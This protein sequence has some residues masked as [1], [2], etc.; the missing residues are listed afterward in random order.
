MSGLGKL[1]QP[2]Y[3][4]LRTSVIFL[5][6]HTTKYQQSTPAERNSPNIQPSLK[7][8]QQVLDQLHS[9]QMSFRHIQ[10]IV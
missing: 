3:N 8:L 6:D 1:C 9:V 7:W 4:E 10:F 2:R 5:Q